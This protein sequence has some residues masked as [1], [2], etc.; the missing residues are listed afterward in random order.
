MINQKNLLIKYPF[1]IN[2]V[3]FGDCLELM[4]E[5]PSNSIDAIVTDPP[6]AIVGGISSGM[7]SQADDQ[8]FGF[9]FTALK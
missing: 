4:A 5:I 8:C 1:E 9:W 2:K 7:T 6:F 3:T